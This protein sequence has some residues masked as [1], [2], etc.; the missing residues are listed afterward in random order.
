MIRK[1]RARF[2]PRGL[3]VL[4]FGDG[5]ARLPEPSVLIGHVAV[6]RLL[7]GRGLSVF[8]H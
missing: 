3:V 4:A 7:D 1:L 8:C 6:W 5:L 2:R